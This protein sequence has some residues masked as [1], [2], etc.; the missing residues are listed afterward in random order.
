MS[1]NLDQ[2]HDPL[3]QAAAHLEKLAEIERREQARRNFW[4]LSEAFETALSQNFGKQTLQKQFAELEEAA[5][6]DGSSID[7]ALQLRYRDR[8]AALDRA[9]RRR[10]LWKIGG[11]LAGVVVIVVA[12]VSVTSLVLRRQGVNQAAADLNRL[13]R[14]HEL[15]AAGKYLAQLKSDS[16]AIAE[17]EEIR[18]LEAVLQDKLQKEQDRR[19]AFR[20]SFNTAQARGAERPD[21]AAL[22]RAKSLAKSS[23]E[24]AEIEAFE[25]R[26]AAHAEKVRKEK[27]ESLR[28]GLAAVSVEIDTLERAGEAAGSAEAITAIRARLETLDGQAGELL[29]RA[30]VDKVVKRL[31]A[32]QSANR[33]HRLMQDAMA[34]MQSAIGNVERYKTAMEGFVADFPQYP[35]SG[36]FAA[37]LKEQTL[38][39]GVLAWNETLES[40]RRADLRTCPAEKA[41]ALARQIEQTA[42][43]YANYPQQA[44]L[45][46]MRLCLEAIGRRS[47]G[48]NGSPAKTLKEMLNDPLIFGLQMVMASDGKRYYTQKEVP[49]GPAAVKVHLNCLIDFALGTRDVALDR[50]SLVVLSPTKLSARAPQSV[51]AEGALRKLLRLEAAPHEWESIFFSLA[52]QLAPGRHSAGKESTAIDPVLQVLLLR[53]V[54]ESGC[55]GSYPLRVGFAKHV[56]MLKEPGFSLNVNWMDP[57]NEDAQRTRQQARLL[58]ERFADVDEA[59][60]LAAVE[61]DRIASQ[62]LVGYRWIGFLNKDDSGV[63]CCVGKPSSEMSGRLFIVRRPGT[64]VELR[65]VGEL[66]DGQMRLTS[67]S[68]VAGLL[69]GQPV[70]LEVTLEPSR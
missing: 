8:I 24:L 36:E 30:D 44:A 56:A 32:L 27:E 21:L 46:K 23:A 16:R 70:F 14:G 25:R 29:L 39:E 41:A 50:D 20:E 18:A 5:G 60:G 49:L 53:R 66:R 51:F 43:K 22:D 64:S 12:A 31:D 15:D 3:A 40:C 42:G 13:L 37:A 2:P 63:W 57:D 67:P 7:D 1:E 34:A 61:L 26:V 65:P 38:W 62:R 52:S 59:G 45:E 68:A 28:R 48:E 17:S 54:L 4:R 6:E 33:Q 58:L 11:A 35:L 10:M 19:E 9:V 55:Q 69:A 47:V